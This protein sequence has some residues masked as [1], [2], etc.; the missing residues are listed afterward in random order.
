MSRNPLA[1][2]VFLAG[3]L[4]VCWIGI[5]YLGNHPLAVAVAA[6][7]TACYLAGAFELLRYRQ[8]TATLVQALP[9][10]GQAGT[11]RRLKRRRPLGCPLAPRLQLRQLL[12]QQFLG[13]EPLPGRVAV[14]LERGD[15][16]IGR[17]VVQKR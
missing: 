7:I 9:S 5:G 16:H 4:A 17:R 12:R 8:A 15:R 13:L 14:V 1:P 6:L 10:I 11:D 3:L 2:L